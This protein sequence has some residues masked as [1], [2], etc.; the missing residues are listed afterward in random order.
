[1]TMFYT[2]KELREL[3]ARQRKFLEIAASD[4]GYCP[5]NPPPR[6]PILKNDEMNKLTVGGL[7][8]FS[9]PDEAWRATDLG[10][11]VLSG[12]TGPQFIKLV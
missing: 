5:Y 8:E 4:D 1:M 7:V 11:A 12:E 2:A 3:T 6:A 10:R 9:D